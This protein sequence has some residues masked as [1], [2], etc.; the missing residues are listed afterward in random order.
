[1]LVYTMHTI[2]IDTIFH[3]CIICSDAF[4]YAVDL[5]VSL[6]EDKTIP[7]MPPILKS[8]TAENTVVSH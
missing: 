1:M 6:F 5:P 8:F 2:H 7:L 3:R 4:P